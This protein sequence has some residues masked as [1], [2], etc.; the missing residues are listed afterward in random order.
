[1]FIGSF[2]PIVFSV[3]SLA[4]LTPNN[5]SRNISKRT[6][7]HEVIKGKPR[8]EYLGPGL[9]AFS[10]DITLRAE[11]GV[12]PRLMLDLLAEMAEGGLAYLLQIGGKPVG[13]HLWSL[14]SVS[15][16]WDNLYSMGELSQ[17]TV[18]ISLTEYVETM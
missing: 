18:K 5:I 14:D 9:Q 3:S 1:M 13:K 4:V 11:Y 2:G 12:R 16:T 8:T 17:A 10:F 7:V 6:T 15:E